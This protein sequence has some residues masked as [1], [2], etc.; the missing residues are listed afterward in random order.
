M[1]DS[2]SQSSRPPRSP[3]SRTGR[4]RSAATSSSAA[5]GPW[6]RST[7]GYTP[8]AITRNRSSSS[9][10]P[11][12]ARASACCAASGSGSGSSR[13]VRAAATS[14]RSPA[15]RSVVA[16]PSSMTS[17]RRSTSR[18]RA[19][20]CRDAC[21]SVARSS[22]RR[23]RSASSAFSA[24]PRSSSA[25]P[26]ATSWI[27]SWSAG[28]IG[29]AGL[30]DGQR[31]AQHRAVEHRDDV[32]D[33]RAGEQ[34]G[35]VRRLLRP[36]G[37]G[38]GRRVLRAPTTSRSPTASHTAARVAPVPSASTWASPGRA[39]SREPARIRAAAAAS[40]EYGVT[41]PV[42]GQP[43]HQRVDPRQHHAERDGHAGP[44]RRTAAARRSA[45]TR[46]RARCPR[47]PPTQHDRDAAG[48]P[49][50]PAAASPRSSG[51]SRTIGGVWAR[52]G[53]RSRPITLSASGRTAAKPQS[54][55]R[56]DRR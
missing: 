37:S 9:S 1:P 21:S 27:S 50:A 47:P 31:G 40:A 34:H 13:S 17:R 55:S 41:S 11:T 3:V 5:A 7:A 12:R 42:V 10:S 18:A 15:S 20:R 24:T 25:A 23:T 16:C 6:S 43:L 38:R 51:S 33:V 14:A 52:P 36:A 2:I 53:A 56:W 30:A 28:V 44:W 29:G 49:A 4:G 19:S 54:P 46:K 35:Q 22:A 39:C 32:V 45:R 48:R 8:R 26:F